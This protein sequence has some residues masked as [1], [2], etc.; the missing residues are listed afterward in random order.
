MNDDITPQ[1]MPHITPLEDKEI[2]QIVID[3]ERNGTEFEFRQ[4]ILAKEITLKGYSFW[5]SLTLDNVYRA[6]RGHFALDIEWLKIEGISKY[7]TGETRPTTKILLPWNCG[8]QPSAFYQNTV[9]TSNLNMNYTIPLPSQTFMR[10]RFKVTVLNDSTW[11]G[12]GEYHLNDEGGSS[13]TFRLVLH[14]EVTHTHTHI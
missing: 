6:S 9:I 7:N 1:P 12:L 4:D 13:F 11:A 2:I 3:S 14:I 8:L 10:K 5:S